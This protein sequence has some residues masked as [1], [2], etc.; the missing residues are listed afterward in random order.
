MYRPQNI[1]QFCTALKIECFVL[2]SKHSFK[3]S[4]CRHAGHRLWHCLSFWIQY[5]SL[6]IRYIP[7]T[8]ISSWAY[9]DWTNWPGFKYQQVAPAIV[10][11]SS[12][13]C[14]LHVWDSR[15]VH[16]PNL[17]QE[18]ILL[19][20]VKESCLRVRLTDLKSKHYYCT[21]RTSTCDDGLHQRWQSLRMCRAPGAEAV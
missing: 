18:S 14:D 19:Q 3:L 2:T 21:F 15:D 13:S 20:L 17:H 16:L 10:L 7:C 11:E 5:N 8:S 4:L 1:Q 12:S 6:F 9:D